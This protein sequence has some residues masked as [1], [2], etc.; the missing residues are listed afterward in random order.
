[1]LELLQA[2][3]VAL[4]VL[5]AYGYRADFAKYSIGTVGVFKR[6]DRRVVEPGDFECA[7]CEG[8]TDSAERRTYFKEIVVAG[9][10]LLRYDK[11]RS[12]YC[13]AHMS[14]ESLQAGGEPQTSQIERLAVPIAEAVA[15]FMTWD[16]SET[17]DDSEF[18]DVVDNVN[19]GLS[20]I[21]IAI[22]VLLA[23]FFIKAFTSQPG[24]ENEI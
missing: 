5:S 23:A 19:A 14:F 9:M 1:M 8:H 24:I 18:S 12:M 4:A 7:D 3:A 13:E 17:V 16:V 2:A 15:T 22:T 6:V 10:P 20:L 11:G 21:P